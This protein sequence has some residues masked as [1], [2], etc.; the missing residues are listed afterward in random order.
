MWITTNLNSIYKCCGQ[1]NH[2]EN[3]KEDS[4]EEEIIT[5]TEGVKRMLETCELKTIWISR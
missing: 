3:F 2:T 5:G 4:Y 1:I